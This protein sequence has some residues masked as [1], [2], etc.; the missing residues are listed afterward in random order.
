MAARRSDVIF[1]GRL[2]DYSYY[3]MDQAVA[4]AL[5]CFEKQIVGQNRPEIRECA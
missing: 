2:A 4:R 1:A 3:N 5:S